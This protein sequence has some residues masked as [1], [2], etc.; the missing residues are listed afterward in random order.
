MGDVM[1]REIPQPTRPFKFR[2]M[3]TV[4]HIPSGRCYVIT[5][6][7]CSRLI[8][9]GTEWEP[10]YG[11]RHYSD[12]PE[13]CRSQKSMEDGTFSSKIIEDINA[14]ME[15]SLASTSEDRHHATRLI[16]KNAIDF[17]KK[18]PDTVLYPEPAYSV[19]GCISLTWRKDNLYTTV[20]FADGKTYSFNVAYHSSVRQVT[21]IALSGHWMCTS[22]SPDLLKS[23]EDN[24][25]SIP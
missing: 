16:I 12:E 21:D 5:A 17:L 22:M 24:F 20:D 19:D 7:P 13:F 9:T 15:L 1:T 14:Y 23:L 3:E 6:L 25:R 2:L 8:K 18:L 4:K 10:A 11:Y